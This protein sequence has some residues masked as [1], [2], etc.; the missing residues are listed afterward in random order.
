M[1]EIIGYTLVVYVILAALIGG[2]YCGYALVKKVGKQRILGII[3]VIYL[4]FVIRH[5]FLFREGGA[6]MH[7]EL[8]PFWSYRRWLVD[9]QWMY[10]KE[11][12]LNILMLVPLGYLLPMLKKQCSL[13]KVLL[14]GCI[15]SVGI[16]VV[17]LVTYLGLCELDDVMNNTLGCAIGYGSYHLFTKIYQKVRRSIREK[18]RRTYD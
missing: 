4:L 1:S 15:L 8:T 14:C 2:N 3:L 6:R 13:K 10:F 7:M 16:E 12:Y 9:K 11:I 17:Q 5:T 18:K